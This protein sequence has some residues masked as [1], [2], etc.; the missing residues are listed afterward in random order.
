MTVFLGIHWALDKMQLTG[1]IYQLVNG[2]FLLTT[3]GGIRLVWGAFNSYDFWQQVSRDDVKAVLPFGVSELYVVA[4]AALQTLNVYWFTQMIKVKER[5][6]MVAT[7]L[8]QRSPVGSAFQ[9][10]R[11]RFE[12]KK[13]E[14]VHA[15]KSK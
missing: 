3:F 4:L 12:P 9:A 7:T 2:V 10:I 11:K 1:S 5:A 6:Y 8:V 14:K 13:Q 15:K